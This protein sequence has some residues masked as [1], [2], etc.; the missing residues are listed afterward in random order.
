MN[1]NLLMEVDNVAGTINYNG[2]IFGAGPTCRPSAIMG[3]K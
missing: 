2:S 3:H 1:N